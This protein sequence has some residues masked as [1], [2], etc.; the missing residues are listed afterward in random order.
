MPSFRVCREA[1]ISAFADPLDDACAFT[2]AVPEYKGRFC[3]DCDKDIIKRLKA[4]GKPEAVPFYPH[5]FLSRQSS[6]GDI[7]PS[8]IV[9]EEV[10]GQPAGWVAE[11]ALAA[12]DRDLSRRRH[13]QGAL[14]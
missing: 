13:S 3:K 14:R 11:I 12:D 7:D 9:F 6:F 10:S 5:E 4:D 8:A 1:G 2:D